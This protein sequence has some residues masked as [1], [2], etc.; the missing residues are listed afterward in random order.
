VRRNLHQKTPCEIPA[1]GQ[2]ELSVPSSPDV[3]RARC[4]TVREVCPNAKIVR[5][6]QTSPPAQMLEE[7]TPFSQT[8][9]LAANPADLKPA[10]RPAV[11]ITQVKPNNLSLSTAEADSS[12]MVAA[13]RSHQEGLVTS[14]LWWFR[15]L[16]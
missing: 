14:A 9:T 7:S 6:L 13:W 5:Q 15:D 3:R 12:T 2:D 1:I 11:S 4:G 10:R 8:Q 16:C